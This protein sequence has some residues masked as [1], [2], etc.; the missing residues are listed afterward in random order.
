[1]Y[2]SSGGRLTA[3]SFPTTTQNSFFFVVDSV[4]HS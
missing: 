1:V 2:S 3:S 4:D